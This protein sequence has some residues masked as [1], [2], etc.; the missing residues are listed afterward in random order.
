[1][2]PAARLARL[3]TRLNRYPTRVERMCGTKQPHPRQSAEREA[4]RLRRT[5][6][7]ETIHAYA[8]PHCR[9]W[10]VGRRPNRGSR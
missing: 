10:H 1:M 7:V 4:A 6:G 9:G 8:C 3:H 5:T 2:E